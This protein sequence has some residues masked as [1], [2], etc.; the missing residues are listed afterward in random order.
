M[1]ERGGLE[2]Q[3]ER[4]FRKFP[5]AKYLDDALR[6]RS[7]PT[8]LF[9]MSPAAD[10]DLRSCW[11]AL[12]RLGGELEKQFGIQSEV[13]MLFTPYEDLQRRTFIALTERLRDEVSAQQRQAV[14]QV[15]FLPDPTVALLWAPDPQASEKIEH[16]NVENAGS[17]VALLP[18]Q[19]FAPPEYR[20]KLSQRLFSVLAARDLYSGRN[21]VTGNDFFGRSEILSDLRL[22]LARGQSVG[23]FGLRRSGKTSVLREFK[24]RFSN[25]QFIV[26]SSDL[27]AIGSLDDAATQLASDLTNAL[28]ELRS[29][30][31]SIWIGSEHE[32]QV[33]SLAEF[34]SRLIRV[35]QKNERYRLILALDEIE[36]LTQFLSEDPTSVRNFLGALRRP[37]QAADNLAL[38]LT[39]VTT[40]YFDYSMLSNDH[41][42]ENPLFGFVEERYLA[43]FRPE[44]TFNL[45]KRLGKSMM[46]SWSD[47]A[48]ALLHS[49]A[50]GFPFLVRDLASKT[51]ASVLEAHGAVVGTEPINVSLASVESTLPG[52][53]EAAGRLWSEIVRTLE[54]HHPVMAEMTRCGS[55]EDLS[56][57]LSLGDESYTSAS[58]LQALGLLDRTAEGWQ[59][60]D[61]LISLQ[62]LSRPAERSLDDIRDERS[63]RI[64]RSSG[65]S[66][67]L[68]QAE[69]ATLEF[70]QS[71]RF[72]TRTRQIDTAI[73][74]AAIRT[75]AAFLNSD[76]GHLLIGVTD[77]G[78]IA[79]LKDD[80]RAFS[81]SQDRM[82]LHLRNTIRSRFGE[83]PS[84]DISVEFVPADEGTVCVISVPAGLAPTFCRDEAKADS[85]YIRDGNQT[86]TL[87]PRE[88]TPYINRRF[89]GSGT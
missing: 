66:Q 70:K 2:A 27:E 83:A 16:W 19:H 22:L 41:G 55:D 78:N 43:P 79:G 49:S 21:P 39:G 20:H 58:A 33:G 9:Y 7:N 30:D 10:N 11:W 48:L 67:L 42:V 59:R 5:S 6:S 26:V 35:A 40:R 3:R 13:L 50:G 64:A 53:T 25:Q 63:R 37:A 65:L 38:L 88:T 76:G 87:G 57:W 73:E 60:S 68:G 14:E 54:R 28:R 46:L 62:R 34:S 18:Q 1:S 56:E 81:D 4:L 69:G 51:R 24:R 12:G 15:R 45:V 32:Q 71:Y 75:I 80:L 82:E 72:N 36:S 31:D 23:L 17:L 44:E 8:P 84:G 61:E 77:D 47:D 85:F 89:S 86:I 74:H 52:W 29:Q